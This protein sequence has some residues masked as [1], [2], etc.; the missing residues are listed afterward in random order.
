[1]AKLPG[2]TIADLRAGKPNP[3]ATPQSK[4]VKS[5]ERQIAIADGKKDKGLQWWFAENGEYWTTLRYGQKILEFEDENGTIGAALL[6]GKRKGQIAPFYR[7]V[8]KDVR[9]GVFDEVIEAAYK[10]TSRARK[11]GSS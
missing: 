11:K 10:A 6:I 9:A 1:M 4:F 8:I 3:R 5:V 2:Y 7:R